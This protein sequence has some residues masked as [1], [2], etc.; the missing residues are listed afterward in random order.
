MCHCR[1][2]PFFLHFDY[3]LKAQKPSHCFQSYYVQRYLM[4]HYILSFLNLQTASSAVFLVG[5]G[6]LP[7]SVRGELLS[8]TKLLSSQKSWLWE[9]G[10]PEISLAEASKESSL[11]QN[12]SLVLKEMYVPVNQ[13]FC[14][15]HEDLLQRHGD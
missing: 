5:Q 2:H 14:C 7:P 3:I 10:C 12:M 8:L 11:E 9:N 13:N 1:E 6:S 4:T 15:Q